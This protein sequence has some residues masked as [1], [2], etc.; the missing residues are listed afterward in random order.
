MKEKADSGVW[1]KI[2]GQY[3]RR[4][5]H[6]LV[7]DKLLLYGK[8]SMPSLHVLFP[9][10]IGKRFLQGILLQNHLSESR[11]RVQNTIIVFYL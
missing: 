10:F 1:A 4:N 2:T 5:H 8:F 6:D 3:S 11:L 9:E 7:V